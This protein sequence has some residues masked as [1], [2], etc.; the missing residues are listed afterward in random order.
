M[1]YL[2]SFNQAFEK[3]PNIKPIYFQELHLTSLHS[4]GVNQYAAHAKRP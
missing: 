4:L 2:S 3:A 1:R